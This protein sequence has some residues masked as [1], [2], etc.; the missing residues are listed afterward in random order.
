MDSLKSERD[1]A[2]RRAAQFEQTATECDKELQKKNQ[3]LERIRRA[4]RG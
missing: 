4:I 1:A 2:R 3:E